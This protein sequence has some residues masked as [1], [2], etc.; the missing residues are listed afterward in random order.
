[1]KTSKVR[2]I[3]VTAASTIALG[4]S[5]TRDK[6]VL[7]AHATARYSIAFG[8]DA[9]LDAGITLQA[10]VAP[11][12]ITREMV[13][14]LIESPITVIGSGVATVGWLEVSGS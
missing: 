1:M 5:K 14:D 6:V 10:L 9:V 13:G 4:V 8:E 3:S 12:V 7:S 11:V 2:T